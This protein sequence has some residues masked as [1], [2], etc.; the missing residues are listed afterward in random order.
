M[1]AKAKARATE[2]IASWGLTGE[3]VDGNMYFDAIDY[4][5][6]NGSTNRQYHLAQI[7][8]DTLGSFVG[9]ELRN[10]FTI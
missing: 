4:S 6:V 8:S 5:V 10:T 7:D 1:N 3:Y 9:Q 2:L